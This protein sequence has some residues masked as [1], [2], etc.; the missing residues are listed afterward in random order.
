M[1]TATEALTTNV[2]EQ[3]DRL[4]P[5]KRVARS[6][7]VT[8]ETIARMESRGEFPAAFNWPIRKKVYQLSKLNAW[9][10]ERTGTDKPFPLAPEAAD[11]NTDDDDK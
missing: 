2:K 5:I 1:T 6:M 4:I 3:Q 10:R 8:K 11:D 7:D 9:W